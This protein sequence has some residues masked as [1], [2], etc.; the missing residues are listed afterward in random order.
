MSSQSKKPDFEW[1][2]TVIPERPPQKCDHYFEFVEG[3]SVECK[4]CHLGLIG[5]YELDNGKLIV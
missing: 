4:K 1:K 2:E 5:V 3:T